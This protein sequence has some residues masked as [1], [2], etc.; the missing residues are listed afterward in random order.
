MK[1]CLCNTFVRTGCENKFKTIIQNIAL[2]GERHN[3]ILYGATLADFLHR[4]CRI[5]VGFKSNKNLSAINLSS[6]PKSRLHHWILWNVLISW[7]ASE[8]LQIVL[9]H[10]IP[11]EKAREDVLKSN[12]V[13]YLPTS[14][15]LVEDLSEFTAH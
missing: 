15:D 7:G 10:R 4:K 13:R 5:F 8:H 6:H 3:W 14:L 11:A 2:T 9:V 12:T 1:H